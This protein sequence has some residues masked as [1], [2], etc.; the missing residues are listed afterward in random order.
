MCYFL[1]FSLSVYNFLLSNVNNKKEIKLEKK[2]KF[3]ATKNRA[4]TSIVLIF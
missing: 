4:H 1:D 2:K 3:P